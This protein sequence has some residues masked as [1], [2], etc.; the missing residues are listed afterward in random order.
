MSEKTVIWT[1]VLG[2]MVLLPA[3]AD[4][5]SG[6]EADVEL[7]AAACSGCHISEGQAQA[8][9]PIAGRDEEELRSLLLGFRDGTIEGTIMNRLAAGYT[10]PELAS[11]AAYFAAETR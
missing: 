11:L 4:R 6:E 7:L 8:L 9:P 3:L 10:E 1:I 5:A 2:A